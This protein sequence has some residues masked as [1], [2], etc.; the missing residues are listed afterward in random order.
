MNSP[1][2]KENLAIANLPKL[3]KV[4][5]FLEDLR[6][7]GLRFDLNPTHCL[8]YASTEEGREAALFW[9]SYIRRMDESIRT[10]AIEALLP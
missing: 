7:H 6:D 3:D 4:M 10:R 1:L 5:E 8:T 2:P 9:H